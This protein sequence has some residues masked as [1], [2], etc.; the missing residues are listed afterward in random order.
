MR[1]G[2][3][4][5]GEC[6]AEKGWLSVSNNIEHSE[7]LSGKLSIRR[8]AAILLYDGNDMGLVGDSFFGDFDLYYGYDGDV[9]EIADFVWCGSN[10]GEGYEELLPEILA[11]TT[12]SADLLFVWGNGEMTGLRVV[13][14]VVTK[15]KV[16]V[17]LE[18]E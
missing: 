6:P 3:G 9:L 18:D 1:G 12:G 17:T 10:S 11:Q 5:A 13:E 8:G 15:C 14:G 4:V 7:Y 2:V 16:K